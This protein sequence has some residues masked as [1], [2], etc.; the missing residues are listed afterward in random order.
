MSTASPAP[1]EQ[2]FNP[3]TVLGVEPTATEAEI[4]DAF[5]R[6]AAKSHPDREDGST[7]RMKDVNM[8]WKI[9]SDPAMR[10][11][12]DSGGGL[13]SKVVLENKARG[14]LVGMVQVL[15]RNTNTQADLIAGLRAAV[16]SQR[17]GCQESRVKTKAELVMLRERLRR[18]KGPPENFIASVIEGEI[19]KGEAHLPVYDADEQV[20]D[21]A[22]QLL[23]DFAYD[24]S[25]AQTFGALG[26]SLP[27]ISNPYSIIIDSLDR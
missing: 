6:E 13:G 18:L 7:E 5:R 2:P 9:L 10:A 4:K 19:Q 24:T 27:H 25:F 17:Q 26:P 21:K 23:A 22:L 8:A 14:L 3:Y 16:T 1:A 15:I 12:F 20:F 11:Q